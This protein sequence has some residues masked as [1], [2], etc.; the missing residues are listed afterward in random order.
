MFAQTL[1]PR[2]SHEGAMGMYHCA[3][4]NTEQ[5]FV[6]R[7]TES[8]IATDHELSVHERVPSEDPVRNRRASSLEWGRCFGGGRF[9]RTPAGEMRARLRRLQTDAACRR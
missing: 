3:L 9:D 2:L 6:A 8:L 1:Q 7:K 4:E 5:F